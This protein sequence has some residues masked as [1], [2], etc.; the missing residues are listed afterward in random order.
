MPGT[1]VHVGSVISCPHGGQTTI[2]SKN[3][4]V[5]VSGM[6]VATMTD[7]F[8]VAGCLF[9]IPVGAGTKPQPCVR[10]TWVAP[11]TRVFVMGQ[12]VVLQLSSGICQSIEQIPQGP[13]IVGATQT[14]VLGM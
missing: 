3:G 5:F 7:L 9:Q 4:R 14:R 1:L 2:A 11:A 6:P 12:P 8:T 13:P 10:I